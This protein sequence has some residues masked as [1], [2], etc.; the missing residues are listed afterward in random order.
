MKSHHTKV[1]IRHRHLAE[2][3][4]LL[5]PDYCYPYPDH[6]LLENTPKHTGSSILPQSLA[7]V[8]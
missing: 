2:C 4:D 3:R 5:L 8:S 1:R 7:R 6:G